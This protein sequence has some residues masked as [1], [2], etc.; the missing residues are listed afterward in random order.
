MDGQIISVGANTSIIHAEAVA[1]EEA[2]KKVKSLYR[3]LVWSFRVTATGK[4]AMAKPCTKCANYLKNLGIS[5]VYYSDSLGG[6]Q[7]IR[8]SHNG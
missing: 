3:A 6:I 4:L 8:L 5:V 7:K 2:L 1:V